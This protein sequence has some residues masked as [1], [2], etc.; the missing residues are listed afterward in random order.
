MSLLAVSMQ[1][2]LRG[3]NRLRHAHRPLLFCKRRPLWRQPQ[4]TT[5]PE[6]H[7]HLEDRSIETDRWMKASHRWRAHVGGLLL[8]MSRPRLGEGASSSSSSSTTIDL[9]QQSHLPQP[10]LLRPS[11]R[12]MHFVTSSP[13][14]LTRTSEPQTNERKRMRRS[15]T[16]IICSLPLRRAVAPRHPSTSVAP[17][18]PWRPTAT[19]A[20]PP[21]TASSPAPASM[22]L[23]RP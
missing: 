19:V 11:M 17:A 12:V 8:P 20:R 2:L 4:Q 14:P 3:R 10:F 1:V 16:R 9:T 5:P 23:A 7:H 21:M 13:R 22:T 15:C 6:P 18:Y